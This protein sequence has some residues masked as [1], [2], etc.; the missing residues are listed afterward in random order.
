ML[1]KACRFE[2]IV[3]Y[4]KLVSKHIESIVKNSTA[5]AHFHIRW[6]NHFNMG[7]ASCFEAKLHSEVKH[8]I[9]RPNLKVLAL[10]E[11]ISLGDFLYAVFGLKY[12]SGIIYPAVFDSGVISKVRDNSELEYL[13]KGYIES[14]KL[15]AGVVGAYWYDVRVSLDDIISWS[16]SIGLPVPP[17][18]RPAEAFQVD[19]GN[20][21][22]SVVLK[23]LDDV[24]ELGEEM[25]KICLIRLLLSFHE[26]NE[27]EKPVIFS[28]LI[29][30]IEDNIGRSHYQRSINEYRLMNVEVNGDSPQ[31][32]ARLYNLVTLFYLREDDRL[33]GKALNRKELFMFLKPLT[34]N[35]C[36]NPV[37]KTIQMFKK[38]HC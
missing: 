28:D 1:C 33:R 35:S 3:I 18:L 5:H 9:D 23:E 31:R 16:D 37:D 25:M 19:S 30:L 4:P 13:L 34:P 20:K 26:N 12:Y 21:I 14:R 22:R 15:R 10:R 11:S 17:A 36:K 6:F 24:F 27:F 2:K 7:D 38:R 29:K 32:F 8:F